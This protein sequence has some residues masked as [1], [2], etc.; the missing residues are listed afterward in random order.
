MNS[1]VQK[2]CP[3]F[4]LKLKVTILIGIHRSPKKQ[5]PKEDPNE[6]Q[7][8]EVVHDVVVASEDVHSE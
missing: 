7:V 8:V 4:D 2:H 6:I 5:V 3:N 1:E